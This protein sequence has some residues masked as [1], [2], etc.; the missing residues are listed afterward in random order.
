MRTNPRYDRDAINRLPRF[1]GGFKRWIFKVDDFCWESSWEMP[2]LSPRNVGIPGSLNNP[3]LGS[4]WKWWNIYFWC[5]DLESSNWNNHIK[6]DVLDTRLLRDYWPP[7][8]RKKA[9]VLGVCVALG[10]P[11]V[12][13]VFLVFVF[14]MIRDDTTTA[15]RDNVQ[16]MGMIQPLQKQNAY[17]KYN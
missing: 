9:L 10:G 11:L 8:S 17:S 1:R 4:G 13:N 14:N 16:R 6:V 12:S 2:R 5:N 3:F 7:W 15:M